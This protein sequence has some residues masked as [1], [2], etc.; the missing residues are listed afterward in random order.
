MTENNQRA[1]YIFYFTATSIMVGCLAFGWF[2]SPLGLGFATW[3]EGHRDLLEGV[4]A[5]S[6]YA[7]I[8]A[9]LI[10]QVIS[11]ILFAYRKR[12]AAYWVPAASI[13]LFLA[14]VALILARVH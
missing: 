11:P 2:M 4:Y 13:A 6:Y 7:G 3:P 1:A 8:P 9:I 14:C 5:L 10:A 12:K